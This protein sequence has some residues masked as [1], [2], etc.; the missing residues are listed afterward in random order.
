MIE[1]TRPLGWK[2]SKILGQIFEKIFEIFPQK[3]L[4]PDPKEPK[5]F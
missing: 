3:W 5:V 2:F 4:Q 1:K